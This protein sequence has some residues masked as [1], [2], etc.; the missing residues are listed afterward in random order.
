MSE[1][2]RFI[3]SLDGTFFDEAYTAEPDVTLYDIER[4]VEECID[5][6]VACVRNVD[7]ACAQLELLMDKYS[8]KACMLSWCSNPEY[9]SI[10]FL[11]VIELY[12]ALD[13]LVVKEIPMLADYPPPFP[14]ALLENMLLRR[15]T[16]LHCLSCA[17]QYL[18]TCHSQSRPGWSAI[19]DEVT[20]D[21]FPV[22][23]YHQ[24][25]ELQQLKTRIE[26]DSMKNVG[27][28]YSFQHGGVGLTHPYDRY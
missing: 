3:L 2:G 21:G 5:D 23:Y 26:E 27:G 18:F 19:S 12:V 28:S 20:E 16:N 6:W 4:L 11:T 24:S 22:H 7:E 14:I 25:P 15:T 9:I 10:M 1:F 8:T 13:K 17:Y